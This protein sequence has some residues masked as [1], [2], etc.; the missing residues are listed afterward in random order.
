MPMY[1]NS[2]STRE[3]TMQACTDTIRYEYSSIYATAD[4]DTSILVSWC[5]RHLYH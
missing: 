3:R 2:K 5:P 1:E 4:T